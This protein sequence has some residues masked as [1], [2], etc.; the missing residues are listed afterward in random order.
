MCWVVHKLQ[1]YTKALPSS[2]A[3]AFVNLLIELW[4]IIAC[5][6]FEKHYVS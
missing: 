5:E 6:T 4:L 1:M 2:W 3:L